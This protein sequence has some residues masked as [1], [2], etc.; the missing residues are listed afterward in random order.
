MMVIVGKSLWV[1]GGSGKLNA[2]P[3]L[4]NLIALATN[5]MQRL[6]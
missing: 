2:S 5:V 1:V 3:R 4:C 6:N